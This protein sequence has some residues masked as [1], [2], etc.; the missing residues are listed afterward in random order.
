MPSPKSIK[1]VQS[2]NGRLVALNRFLAKH[3]EKSLLF[4]N[5]FKAC[6]NRNK[7]L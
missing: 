5:T 6:I 3:A 1:E 7:F 2:L 4:I